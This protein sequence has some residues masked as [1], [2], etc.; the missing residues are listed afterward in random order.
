[1]LIIQP[2]LLVLIV[3]HANHGAK[4]TYLFSVC[5]MLIMKPGLLILSVINAHMEPGVLI[6]SVFHAHHGA[7][8]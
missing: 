4:R 3:F 5:S 2:D 1:M 8:E 7:N 6:L